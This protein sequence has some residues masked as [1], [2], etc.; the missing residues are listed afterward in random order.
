MG[1][2]GG[3]GTKASRSRR[4]AKQWSLL[5][6]ILGGIFIVIVI[7]YIFPLVGI[8]NS[9]PMTTIGAILLIVATLLCLD[10]IEEKLGLK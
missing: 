4:W 5:L 3:T 8:A 6:T 9:W 2:F 1:E 7:E 10:W